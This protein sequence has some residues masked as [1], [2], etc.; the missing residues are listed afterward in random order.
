VAQVVVLVRVVRD[1]ARMR[2]LLVASLFLLTSAAA[3]APRYRVVEVAR[4]L[5]VPWS[6]VFAPDG[7]MLVTERPGRL[8]VIAKGVLQ[9]QPLFTFRDV[10]A[11]S[12]DG[13]MGLALHPDFA[14]NH[15]LYVSYTTSRDVRV[16]RYRE[17]GTTLVEPKTIVSGLPGARYHAGCRLKFGPDRKLYITTGD[18]TDRNIAQQMNSLGGKVLRVNDDGSIPADNPFPNSPI[19]T[20]GNRNPQGI[21]WDPVSGL[22]FE[23]E[24]GPSGFDGP[25][26]GDEVN[27]LERGR[28]YGW[29]LVHHRESRS[30][31]VSPLLEYTPAVAP[32]SGVFWRNDFW[33]GCLRGE[34]VHHVVLDAKNRRRVV[35]EEKL[36]TEYGR[37]RDVAAGPDGALYFSTSNRDGRG[38]VRAGDDRIYR[39]VGR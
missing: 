29:P 36:F 5:E 27:I 15:L 17:T 13:L 4:G 31:L 19:W 1:D 34:H 25:G 2:K 37:I 21:D 26:G 35:S 39:V 18:A 6:I 32:A 33:F 28:N 22:L 20:L 38:N 12:E 8:R 7:R 3:P 16:I 23:T 14:R 24:H 10:A 30:G 11:G 9:P